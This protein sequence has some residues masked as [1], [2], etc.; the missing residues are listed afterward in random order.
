MKKGKNSNTSA[1]DMIVWNHYFSLSPLQKTA[2]ISLKTQTCISKCDFKPRIK[3]Q[4]THLAKYQFG[5]IRK[6]TIQ[7]QIGIDLE[8]RE[9]AYT[10]YCLFHL[11]LL[12]FY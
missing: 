9:I 12:I 4:L 8:H 11:L 5:V 3:L 10:I 1:T 2:D 7:L 6:Q